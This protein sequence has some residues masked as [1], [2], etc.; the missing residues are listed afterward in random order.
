MIKITG[1]VGVFFLFRMSPHTGY[2][3]MLNSVSKK[4]NITFSSMCK[5]LYLAED[6]EARLAPITEFVFC[7]FFLDWI[8]ERIICG[9]TLIIIGA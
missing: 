5:A 2:V 3:I 6:I 4:R 1:T 8:H 7:S 9:S